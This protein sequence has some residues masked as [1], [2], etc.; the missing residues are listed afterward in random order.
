MPYAEY[1]A[2][3]VTYRKPEI[4]SALYEPTERTRIEEYAA[5]DKRKRYNYANYMAIIKPFLSVRCRFHFR[6]VPQI[7]LIPSKYH[8]LYTAKGNAAKTCNVNNSFHKMP[9]QPLSYARPRIDKVADNRNN[10]YSEQY[11]Q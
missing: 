11:I 5:E 8:R 10:R 3:E 9:F 6:C 4:A 2:E 7:S 1:L